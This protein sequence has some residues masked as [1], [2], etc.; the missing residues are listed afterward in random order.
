MNL[1]LTMN[2]LKEGFWPTILSLSDQFRN[3]FSRQPLTVLS[4]SLVNGR[5]RAMS[6]INDSV[7]KSWEKPG[8]LLRSQGLYQAISDAID[9]TEFPGTHISIL[10]EDSRCMNFTVQLPEMPLTDL[11]PILE[12]KV[13][14][15]K[16]WDDPPVWRYHIGMKARGKASVHLEVWPQNLVDEIIQV[17]K[18]LDLQLQ[19]LAPLSALTESQLRTLFVEPGEATLLISILEGKVTFIA[20][21]EDGD[22]ILTR[23]LAPVQ[24]WVPLGERI[25][26]EVNRTL[27]FITQQLNVT[28]PQIWFLSEEDQLTVEEVQPHISTPIVSCPI[29]PDWKYWL[30]VGATLPINLSNNFTPL[31]VRRAPL[32][33]VFGKSLAAIVV[34]LVILSVGATASLEGYVSKN[35]SRLQIAS[36]QAQALQADHRHWMSQL[37][38][39]NTERQWAQ[40]ITESTVPFLEGPLLSYLGNIVPPQ[41]IL[42]KAVV[43]RT[44]DM[45]DLELVGRTS[46][47]LSST[48]V[49][50]DQLV[51]QLAQGPYHVTVQDG[52]RD[53]LLSQTNSQ[54]IR[55]GLQPSYQ[56][57]LK[58]SLS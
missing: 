55:K 46:T 48:L 57:T 36:A 6:I 37:V 18:D 56:W 9:H 14:Q 30:W 7:H 12:R 43:K 50:M 54:V 26:T 21:G 58:G 33:K 52:W 3:R 53:Q 44:N 1:S 40:A 16:P 24:D 4:V 8:I 28:I 27:M 45:W 13:Q 20:G 29:T 10:L 34:G 5:F 19:H 39:I 32:Q 35:Q 38:A 42:H 49:L 11:I 17:C 51:R 47:N 25:A 41:V 31:E 2:A 22:P 15:V 23:H